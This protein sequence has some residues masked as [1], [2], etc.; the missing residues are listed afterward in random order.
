[1]NGRCPFPRQLL[2]S[3]LP[4]RSKLSKIFLGS[5]VHTYSLALP[6]TSPHGLP[7]SPRAMF[8]PSR[9]PLARP[10]WFTRWNAQSFPRH[11]SRPVLISTPWQLMNLC[12]SL[13]ATLH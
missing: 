12:R 9:N 4:L 13:P 2:R 5:T 3:W 11:R 7:S 8:T 6:G 10:N 1:M